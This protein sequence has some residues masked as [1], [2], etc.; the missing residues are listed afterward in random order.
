MLKSLGRYVKKRRIELGLNTAELAL[1]IG[2]TNPA[3]GMNR[4]IKL[5]RDGIVH[6]D[7]LKKLID[8]FKLDEDIVNKLISKDR[9][10]YEAEYERWLNEPVKMTYTIRVM[11]AVYLSY[12]IP[13]EVTSEEGVA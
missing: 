4:I 7:L 5:E 2:Y 1:K 12:D 10:A 13:S 9:E 3:K 11:P 6:P 8:V